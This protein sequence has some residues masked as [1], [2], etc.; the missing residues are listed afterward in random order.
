VTRGSL[1]RQL[2][3][4]RSWPAQCRLEVSLKLTDQHL[5]FRR[6]K[7]LLPEFS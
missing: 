1:I 4:D 2:K 6:S 3:F 5:N 7:S